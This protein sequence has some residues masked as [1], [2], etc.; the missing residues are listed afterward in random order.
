MSKLWISFSGG[1]TSAYMAKRISEEYPEYKKVVVFANTG[2]E[3]EETLKFVQMCTERWGW[4]TVWV[5]AVVDPENGK[6]T[7]HKVVNFETAS[8]NGEPFEAVMAKYGISNQ[9]YPHCTRELKLQPML[10][11][12]RSLGWKK[13]DYEVAIGIRGDE[14]R[15][16]DK[17]AEEKGIVYPLIDWFDYPLDK[18]DVNDFWEDQDFTLNLE[19]YQGNCKWCWKK[20]FK[21]HYQLIQ[22]S[23]EIYDF[24][25]KMEG[26][27]GTV[28]CPI[29][30]TDRV[31]FRGN[32]STT[33]L[34]KMAGEFYNGQTLELDLD[35]D[36][37][38]S[39]SCEVV[40]E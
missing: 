3:H 8:R 24:P 9:A 27:Y 2:Q 38:C 6:G 19:E 10:S 7:K 18:V 11:Y 36:G 31:F 23:P 34:F 17:K 4:N 15:R 26:L 28:K 32:N 16:C 25:R 29:Q 14:Q 33:N 20:S 21:K 30:G 13:G 37:G 40:I 1:K 12:I 39:E 35:A 22:E 5:E